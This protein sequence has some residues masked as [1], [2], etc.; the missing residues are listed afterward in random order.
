MNDHY[1]MNK[2]TLRDRSDEFAERQRQIDL[3]EQRRNEQEK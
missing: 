3:R 1:L 2:H